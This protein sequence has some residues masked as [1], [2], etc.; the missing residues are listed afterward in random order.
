MGAFKAP[1]FAA[2]VASVVVVLS[3]A[4][5]SSGGSVARP[6]TLRWVS[7]VPAKRTVTGVVGGA[8]VALKAADACSVTASIFPNAPR[9]VSEATMGIQGGTYENP[10]CAGDIAR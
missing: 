2:G 1:L 6:T 5:A 8:C 9:N 4:L 10:F 3:P 7:V